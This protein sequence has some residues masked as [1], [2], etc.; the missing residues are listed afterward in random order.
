MFGQNNHK[1]DSLRHALA[2]AA[3]DTSKINTFN[4][5]ARELI[6]INPDTALIVAKSVYG[7]A[8]RNSFKHG[9]AVSH[10]VKG[11]IYQFLGDYNNA[12]AQE[13]SAVAMFLQ[14]GDKRN[15]SSTYSDIGIIF[16]LQSNYSKA[17]EYFHKS[18]NIALEIGSKADVGDAYSNLGIVYSHL[19][20]YPTAVEYDIKGL[21]INERLGNKKG[22]A[23]NYTN[24]GNVYDLQGNYKKALE[25]HYKALELNKS[26][27]SKRGIAAEYTNIGL[28]YQEQKDFP[29]ALEYDFNGLQIDQEMSSKADIAIDYG[30]I[31]GLFE[32]IYSSD[33]N[34]MGCVYINNGEK[35]YIPYTSLL[36]SSL[37]FEYRALKLDREVGDRQ[38]EI[39][40]LQGIANIFDKKQQRDKAIEYRLRAHTIADSI[41]AIDEKMGVAQWLKDDYIAKKDYVTAIKYLQEIIALKDTIFGQ[42]KQKSLGKQEAQFDFDKKL[43]EQEKEREKDR[44]LSDEQAKRG[45]LVTISVSAG[46]LIVLVFLFLLYKRFKITN[47]QKLVI[48][49]QKREVDNAYSKLNDTHQQLQERD[50][51]ITDSITYAK[52]I[53]TAILPSEDYLKESLGEYFVLFK[54]RDV[55]SGDFYWCHKEGDKVI[56]AVADCTGHGVPGAFMSMIGSSLLNQVVIE[57][58]IYDAAEILDSLRSNLLKQLQQKGQESLNRDGMDISLC[59]WDKSANTVQYSGANNPAYVLKDILGNGMDSKFKIHNNTLIELLPDKQPIGYLEGKMETKFTSFTMQLN[60]GDQVYLVSDGYKDQFGGDKNKK[61]T[62]QAF[63]DTIISLKSIP[64]NEQKK[65]L[66]DTIEKWKGSFAQTDDICLIGFTV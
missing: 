54:P 64:L 59:V 51:D 32:A 14:L 33:K 46:L 5:L 22:M 25:Y 57:S 31:G 58:K 13:D 11:K 47:Q 6:N 15:V 65:Y 38:N 7:M 45:R 48:E 4:E 42:D 61:F 10:Q 1:I 53:Q 37:A 12:V 49:D 27:E 9:E 63:R 40:S 41:G 19:G 29:K 30:N 52:R 18:L 3:N 50:K 34:K 60:K 55:V 21:E 2:I 36:D 26:I 16:H 28:V 17:A 43:F 23:R 56:V 35:V 8:K 39:Y 20:N 44:L 66:D 24:L 62:S